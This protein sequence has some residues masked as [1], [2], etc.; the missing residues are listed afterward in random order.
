V[1]APFPNASMPEKPCALCRNIRLL[2]VSVILGSGAGLLADALGAAT[3]LSMA[4]TFFAAMVP[5]LWQARR[6]RRRD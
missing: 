2:L 4:T 1:K 3:H 5:I 6:Q